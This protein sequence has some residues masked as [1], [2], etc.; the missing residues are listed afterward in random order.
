MEL[1]M[2]FGTGRDVRVAILG[3]YA[4]RRCGI[5]TFTGDLH[6]ALHMSGLLP[7]VIAMDD[8]VGAA[9]SPGGA[10]R[11]SIPEHDRPAYAA[12]GRY[13]NGAA[14]VLL[15]QHEFG[16][17]GGDSGSY[18]LD[19]LAATNLPVV[20]TLH[21]VLTEPNA[22]QARVMRALAAR[23]GT[24]VVMADR[25]RQILVQSYGVPI[26]RIAVIPHGVPDR[27]LAEPSAM[28]S[29]LGWPEVPT[30]LSFGLLSPG[31]GLETMIEALPG[32]T[33]E[34]PALRY[35]I[36]GATHP[37]IVKRDG[38]ERYRQSL[39]AR[40]EALGVRHNVTFD[41]RF[42]E[43]DELCDCLQASDIYV[44]PYLSPAQ[45]T[46]GTLAYA[47][48]LGV[49]VV[50]TRYWHALELLGSRPKQLVDS[51]SPSALAASIGRL[52]RDPELRREAALD[53]YVSSAGHG[54]VSVGR[55]YAAY[56][57]R[58]AAVCTD[59]QPLS[60]PALRSNAA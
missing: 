13:L 37:H 39:A 17:F 60:L 8:G 14:D 29:R 38:G 56:L 55:R 12:A 16:I 40:A 32:L 43:I 50:S 36:L 28:R 41:N 49:P 4:P 2:A 3:N 5:A 30:L 6:R 45:I 52:L 25:G 11:F 44:T 15:I 51:G 59:A 1:L 57:R 22:A 58:A 20:T 27:A 42:V 33:A 18:L 31:K 46:S 34:F 23:S 47:H 48:G 19:L 54:W 53:A 24:L 10:V 26:G 7:F 9:A 35:I 21:T